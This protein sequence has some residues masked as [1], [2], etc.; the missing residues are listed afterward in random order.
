M[1]AFYIKS[2]VPVA[3]GCL[4]EWVTVK[5]VFIQCSHLHY[6]LFGNLKI[7][8]GTERFFLHPVPVFL[9]E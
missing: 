7:K 1:G 3:S 6:A 2:I 4:Q 8:T 5:I 9:C